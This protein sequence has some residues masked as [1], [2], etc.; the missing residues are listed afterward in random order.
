MAMSCV[1]RRALADEFMEQHARDHVEGLEDAF[2]L[3]RDRSKGRDLHFAVVEEELQVLDRGDVGEVA[4]VELEHVRD[5]RQ[6]EAQAL[7]VVFE[8]GEALDILRHLLVLGIGDKD[9]AVHPAQ[10]P[11]GE[12]T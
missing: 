4:F 1:L 12:M 9:N 3:V 11:S 5:V 6:V 2:A 10:D 8:V 7:E